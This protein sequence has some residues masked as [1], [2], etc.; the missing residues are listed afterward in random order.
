MTVLPSEAMVLPPIVRDPR[1]VRALRMLRGKR[2]QCLVLIGALRSAKV[3]N[4]LSSPDWGLPWRFRNEIPKERHTA[5]DE[6][7]EDIFIE[8]AAAYPDQF[9]LLRGFAFAGIIEQC[10]TGRYQGL[11]WPAVWANV[12]LTIDGVEVKSS[13]EGSRSEFDVVVYSPEDEPLLRPEEYMELY[14]CKLKCRHLS[15]SQL[16]FYIRASKS[17]SFPCDICVVTSDLASDC[18]RKMREIF[19]PGEMGTDIYIVGPNEFEILT[20]DEISDPSWRPYRLSC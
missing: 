6:A 12:C 1:Y 4:D 8:L 15:R 2:D 11:L 20:T 7:I 17:C 10:L 18:I 5:Q 19:K 16:D 3:P 9:D 14:E 13:E